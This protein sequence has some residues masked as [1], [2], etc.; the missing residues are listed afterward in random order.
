ME[1]PYA[2][3]SMSYS[4]NSRAYNVNKVKLFSLVNLATIVQVT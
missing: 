4:F 2:T 1:L 3:G